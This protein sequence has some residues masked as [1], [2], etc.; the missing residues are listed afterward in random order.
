LRHLPS[1]RHRNERAPS[2]AES[3][4]SIISH[5]QTF[6]QVSAPARSNN[7]FNANSNK[8]RSRPS[9]STPTEQPQRETFAVPPAAQHPS[10]PVMPFPSIPPTWAPPHLTLE[11]PGMP[12]SRTVVSV[13]SLAGPGI[14][15][16]PPPDY[17][18]EDGDKGDGEDNKIYCFC[19]RPSF[20]DMVACDAEDCE[21]E[22]VRSTSP[23][24][25]H[26]FCNPL[27]LCSSSTWIVSGL[28]AFQMAN[29][30]VMNARPSRA[31]SRKSASAMRK[32]ENQAA[33]ATLV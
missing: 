31:R 27:F 17:D 32:A 30:S 4:L 1:I 26:Y 2:P 12:S 13:P 8:K 20:G 21:R 22:W 14:A 19:N 11:G 24:L 16:P 7:R 15:A 25:S 5:Q 9:A 3:V 6:A 10:L 29:G 33:R 23:K 28:R 18:V